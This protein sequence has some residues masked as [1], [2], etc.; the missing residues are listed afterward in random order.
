MLSPSQLSSPSEL[1]H[2]IAAQLQEPR[3]DLIAEVIHHFGPEKTRELLNETLR[4]EEQGGLLVDDGSRRRTPGG[5]FLYLARGRL[6]ISQR[7]QLF[8]WSP[9]WKRETLRRQAADRRR[10]LTRQDPDAFWQRRLPILLWLVKQ[11]PRGSATTMKLTLTG[12]PGPIVNQDLFI[13]TTMESTGV[14]PSLPRG[15]PTPPPNTMVFLVYIAA[16][17]WRKIEAEMVE[18]RLREPDDL[19][20]V[21]GYPTYD[22]EAGRMCLFASYVTTRRLRQAR[23][24][25]QGQAEPEP[26]G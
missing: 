1:A 10:R 25:Q 13:I 18:G 23:R 12:Q 16:K 11:R 19:L 24:L 4:I 9:E 17:H 3:T 5:V 20:I 2:E 8:P 6:P 26:Q 14:T 22:V 21:E 15:L 7:L